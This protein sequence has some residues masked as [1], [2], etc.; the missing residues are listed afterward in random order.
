MGYDQEA[1]K[2]LRNS[3]GLT[4]E[5]FAGRIGVSKQ[6]VSTWETGACEPR[7]GSLTRIAAAFRVPIDSFFLPDSETIVSHSNEVQA[8]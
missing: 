6:V 7:V 2:R 4:I 5:Q 1:I 8:N 3:H